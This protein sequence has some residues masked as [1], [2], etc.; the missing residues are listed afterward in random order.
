MK[1]PFS[2]LV[3]AALLVFASAVAA[4]NV[5]RVSHST[6]PRRANAVAPYNL[7]REVAVQ[8]V[9]QSV[10]RKPTAGLMFGGHVMVA[11]PQGTVDVQIGKF[12]LRGRNSLSFASGESVVAIGM[13]TTFHNH[14]VLL[15]RLLQ[16]PGRTIEI[17]NQHGIEISPAARK[18]LARKASN[19]GGAQ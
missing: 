16:T 6:L 18:A 15:A 1:S 7:S 11:T 17:R 4:Q 10:V 9:V 14:P 12:L 5:S 19:V 8:G 3:I 2:G 13:M